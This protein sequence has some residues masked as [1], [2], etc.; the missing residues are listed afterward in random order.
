MATLI[1][2]GRSITRAR[3]T[4][5]QKAGLC[6]EEEPHAMHLGRGLWL[7]RMCGHSLPC[8][9]HTPPEGWP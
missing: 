3:I 8:P 7:F 6:P 9:Y 5:L 1:H 2:L 4:E